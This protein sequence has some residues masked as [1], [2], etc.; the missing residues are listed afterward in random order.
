MFS[1]EL[2]PD[3]DP[4]MKVPPKRKGNVCFDDDDT[5][6]RSLPSMKVPPKRKGNTCIFGRVRSLSHPQ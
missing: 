4:S 2:L 3:P 6:A 1:S 5:V